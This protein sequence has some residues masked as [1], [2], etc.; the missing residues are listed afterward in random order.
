MEHLT[1]LLRDLAPW[2]LTFTVGILAKVVHS[3]HTSFKSLGET[4]FKADEAHE[5]VSQRVPEYER[6]YKTWL[7]HR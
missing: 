3:A 5:E 2:A 4:K 1:S 6:R 7:A